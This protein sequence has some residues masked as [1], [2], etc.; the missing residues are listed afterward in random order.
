MSINSSINKWSPSTYVF[1]IQINDFSVLVEVFCYLIG[2]DIH[3]IIRQEMSYCTQNDAAKYLVQGFIPSLASAFSRYSRNEWNSLC[4]T[5]QHLLVGFCHKDLELRLAFRTL[6]GQSHQVCERHTCQQG[7]LSCNFQRNLGLEIKINS[8]RNFRNLHFLL[9]KK[10]E[11]FF[12]TV[13]NIVK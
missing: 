6:V 2:K 7:S 5:S 11:K 13:S 9:P 4:T 8:L 1:T 3:L 10:R 12:F